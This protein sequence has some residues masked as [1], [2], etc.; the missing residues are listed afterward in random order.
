VF[1]LA[2]TKQGLWHKVGFRRVNRTFPML[3]RDSEDYGNPSVRVS[4][5]WYVWQPNEPFQLVGRLTG[6]LRNAEPGV[7][8]PPDCVIERI[9][10]GKYG[11]QYPTYDPALQPCA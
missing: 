4:E 2:G 5:R 11:I 9:R 7:V 8:V 3:F 1:L 10:T 6:D